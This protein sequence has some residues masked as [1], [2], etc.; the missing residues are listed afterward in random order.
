MEGRRTP[1]GNHAATENIQTPQRQF[2]KDSAG[3]QDWTWVSG[4][5]RQRLTMARFTPASNNSYMIQKQS[6]FT[7]QMRLKPIIPV[8][9]SSVLSI[10]PPHQLKYYI[11]T[12]NV[13]ERNEHKHFR[14][15]IFGYTFLIMFS[16]CVD[17]AACLSS[18]DLSVLKKNTFKKGVWIKRNNSALSQKFKNNQHWIHRDWLEKYYTELLKATYFN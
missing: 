3:D 16:K 6:S 1:R 7:P 11:C 10:R 15:K 9:R 17:M 2:H 5:A 14:S 12:Q 8:L 4:A 13:V 18:G